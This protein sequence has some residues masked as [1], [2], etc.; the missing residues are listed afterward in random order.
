MTRVVVIGSGNPDR[1]DDGAGVAVAERV[2]AADIPGVRVVDGGDLTTVVDA[3]DSSEVVYVIDSCRS[4]AAPGTVL[5]LDATASPLAE[6]GQH[7]SHGLGT[8]EGIELARALGRL[9]ARVVV[10]AIEGSDY[11]LGAP[12]SPAVAAAVDR[13]ADDLLAATQAG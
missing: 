13:V 3:C 12:L 10:Y 2:A 1:G 9:R 6:S 11:D 8:A 7:S 4:G 5:Q